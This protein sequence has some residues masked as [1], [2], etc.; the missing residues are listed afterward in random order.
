MFGITF[1]SR[2]RIAKSNEQ[3]KNWSWLVKFQQPFVNWFSPSSGWRN[4]GVFSACSRRENE[5]PYR[6][7]MTPNNA[8]VYYMSNIRLVINDFRFVPGC[9]GRVLPAAARWETR[10]IPG[11]DWFPIEGPRRAESGRRDP[12]RSLT[13]GTAP[14]VLL[15]K[16]NCT[17]LLPDITSKTV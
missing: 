4:F 9:R 11:V 2:T 14:L 3:L 17:G 8:T 1:R 16:N 15:K 6:T 13:Q 7:K 12:L 10:S 5:F